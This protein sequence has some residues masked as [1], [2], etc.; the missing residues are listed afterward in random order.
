L[1]SEKFSALQI[2]FNRSS[3]FATALGVTTTFAGASVHAFAT[4]VAALATAL[5]FASILA[6]AVVLAC[7]ARRRI[8]ARCAGTRCVGHAVVIRFRVVAADHATGHDAG[9]R[10]RHEDCPL[11]SV[12]NFAYWFCF[13]FEFQRHS[14]NAVA[15]LP[16]LE[17]ATAGLFQNFFNK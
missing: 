10:R 9:H 11:S 4:F 2:E 7:I 5:P 8:S 15:C 17:T 6:L 3:R 13:G 14:A 16:R 1:E 12:H